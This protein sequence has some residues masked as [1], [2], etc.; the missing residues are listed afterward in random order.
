MF[1]ALQPQL[2]E[3]QTWTAGTQRLMVTVRV[4][5]SVNGHVGIVHGGVTA[6]VVDEVTGAGAPVRLHGHMVL[7]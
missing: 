1:E 2:T 4:S 3:W 6:L 5:N 7:Y